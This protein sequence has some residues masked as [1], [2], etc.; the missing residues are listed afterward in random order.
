MA[1]KKNSRKVLAVAL[2]I[3]GIAG[4]SLA[5]ASQL[6]ITATPNIST[7]TQTFG[8]P[9]DD[10]VNVAYTLAGT[11]I[12]PTFTDV[13]I[14]GI[15]AAC[16]TVPVKAISYVLTYQTWNGTG[17]DAAAT[18]TASDVQITALN[19]GAT[20]SVTV[21]LPPAAQAGTTKFVSIAVTIK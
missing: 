15:A 4:L 21:A 17:Y 6:N 19:S 12:A 7:G 8:D 10:A 18:V 1:K 16:V 3:M 5:S 9:C 13:K 2:G 14:S 20:N 11:S